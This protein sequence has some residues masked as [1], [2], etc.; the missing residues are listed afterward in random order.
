[1]D[2]WLREVSSSKP[3]GLGLE[4]A[5]RAKRIGPKIQKPDGKVERAV[6]V[7]RG[8]MASQC[9][10]HPEGAARGSFYLDVDWASGPGW[11]G[12]PGNVQS[13]EVCF[14]SS[15]QGSLNTKENGKPRELT[16]PHVRMIENAFSRDGHALSGHCPGKEGWMLATCRQEPATVLA[17][18]KSSL[19]LLG[20]WPS[21]PVVWANR[22]SRWHQLSS[23]CL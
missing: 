21:S 19:L 9:L 15:L 3:H 5:A 17:F 10:L 7:A 23:S 18:P 22:F 13:C 2:L 16:V 12:I 1:M 11:D 14:N 20:L 6:L 8:L 4:G